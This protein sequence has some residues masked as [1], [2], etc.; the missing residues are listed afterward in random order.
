LVLVEQ[1]AGCLQKSSTKT[2]MIEPN[3]IIRPGTYSTPD[4]LAVLTPG[5]RALV[6]RVFFAR[7]DLADSAIIFV[8]A[9][10]LSGLPVSVNAD[11]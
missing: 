4:R 1:I 2:A 8:T 7:V 5:R 10:D 3:F 9:A 6:V 11:T